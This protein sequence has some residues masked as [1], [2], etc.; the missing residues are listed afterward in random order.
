[1][2]F[3]PFGS[4]IYTLAASI[5]STATTITLNSFVEPVSGTPYTM[6]LLN[7]NIAYG[8]IAP[9]TTSAEFISFTG[10]VQNGNGTATLTGVTRGLNKKY[11]FTENSSFKLPHSGQ[12]QF[13]I[14]DAPQ[15]FKKY[16][17]LEND[18]IVTGYWSVPDPINGQQIANYQWV[19]SVV[20]GG[21]VTF[22]NQIIPGDAGE[23]IAAGDWVYLNFSDGLWYKT[24][25]DVSA[26]SVDVKIGVSQGAGTAGNAIAN[27]GVLVSGLDSSV[28]YTAGQFYYLSNTA[29]AVSTTPG[30]NNVIAGIGDANNKLV[31]L[32]IYN[33][34]GLTAG[35][36]AAAAG[37]QG[38]PS[39]TNRYVTQDN[40]TS[41]GVDQSQTTQDS[42]IEVGEANATGKKNKVA[43]S[44]VAG[45]TKTRGAVIYKS[46][47]SGTFTGTVTLSIQADSAGVP[48]GSDLVS[49]TLTNAEWEAYAAGE[50]EFDYASEYS[51]LVAGT[52]YWLVISTS[53]S[54]NTNHINIGTSLTGG[55]AS[56]IVK[57]DNTADGWVTVSTIDLYFKILE[58]NDSQVVQTQSNGKISNDLID[59]STTLGNFVGVG[60]AS[61]TSWFNFQLPFNFVNSTDAPANVWTFGGTTTPF[62][63]AFGSGQNAVLDADQDGLFINYTD[64]QIMKF[65]DSTKKQV[66][67][68]GVVHF[69]LASN[70]AAGWGFTGN[71]PSNIFGAAG[72]N[73]VGVCFTDTTA[74]GSWV[75]YTGTGAA[76]TQTAVTISTPGKHVLRI[77]YDPANATPQ[78]R[79]YIDG[80]LVA[81]H[82]TNLPTSVNEV[83]KV[84]VGNKSTGDNTIDFLSCPMFAQE[85]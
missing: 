67:M 68:E 44:F 36:I 53:T 8:T 30:T 10:I 62:G 34:N 70:Y 64:G 35:E 46:A 26:K 50:V 40:V 21:S 22:G 6:A 18:E 59:I 12:S 27:G 48:S 78:A 20:N 2:P 82:T 1:M 77:E 56:G 28:S 31:I 13:I 85:Q 5:S 3:N 39:N 51:S 23:T 73:V 80:I 47:N 37:S 58:G 69:E 25:A 74:S 76:R 14:S 65:N 54:D 61:N 52:T 33:P 19:L 49:K 75:A 81:T 71:T 16:G 57:Y 79:F 17:T 29:G 7:T 4:G 41:A 66:I 32:N 15:L 72:T 42:T 60:P 45:K 83:I 11:P 84:A 43:Q 24:D 38:V 9:K 55:Y 63:G